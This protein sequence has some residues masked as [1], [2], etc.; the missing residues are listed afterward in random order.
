MAEQGNLMSV[1]HKPD[2]RVEV[3]IEQLRDLLE[4]LVA[5]NVDDAKRW[6]VAAIYQGKKDLRERK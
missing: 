2:D 5:G 4:V 1:A 6:L 3:T